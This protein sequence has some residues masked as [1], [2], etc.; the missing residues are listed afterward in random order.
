MLCPQFAHLEGH[1]K[2]A[3]IALSNS[4]AIIPKIVSKRC[5]SGLK[6][7]N[8]GFT[9]VLVSSAS[10]AVCIALRFMLAEFKTLWAFIA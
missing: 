7:I 5:V 9:N 10:S 6:I 1:F 8:P 4:I 3:M 2:V